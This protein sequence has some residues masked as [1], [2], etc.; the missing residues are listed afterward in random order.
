MSEKVLKATHDGVLEL[1]D[2]KI[3]AAVLNDKDKTRVLSKTEIIKALGKSDGGSKRGEAKLPRFISANNLKP[4]ISIELEEAILSP[5]KYKTKKGNPAHG[6]PA[7]F[8][9]QICDIWL[10]AKD[11]LLESQKDTAKRAYILIRGLAHVGIISLV[12]EA[13]GYQD[14][15]NRQE[16]QKILKLYISEE[17]LPWSKRF[18]D[19]FYKQ[20]FRLRGWPY[21][22]ES[23]KKRPGVIG[24]WTNKLIYKQLPEG[25][26]A[27]LKKRTPKNT[28]GKRTHHFH[29]LFTTDIGHPH[30]SNQ[31]T[32]VVTLMR[33][34]P[35]W[36]KF[37]SLFNRAYGQQEIDFGDD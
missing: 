32:A 23:I 37:E 20:M 24:T 9:P 11:V 30:L 22:T 26:L 1:G 8:L 21:D 17:L 2:F 33:V 10:N 16:L 6:I 3:F 4:Y 25:V 31:I 5:I 13:T 14:D 18:P 34:S 36:R 19:E 29:R 35:T 7:N 27:E 28:K 15:R 12:D